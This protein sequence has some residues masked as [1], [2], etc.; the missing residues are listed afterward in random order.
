[1]DQIPQWRP[2]PE[3]Y[4][5]ALPLNFPPE[6]NFIYRSTN[7]MTPVLPGSSVLSADSFDAD[8]PSHDVVVVGDAGTSDICWWEL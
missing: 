6:A 4:R 3:C 1:M 8:L 7:N 2:E 5:A